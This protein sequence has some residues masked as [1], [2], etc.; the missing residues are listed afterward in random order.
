MITGELKGKVDRIWDH[1]WSNGLS[2]PLAVI[3]QI[4]YLLFMKRL[5]ELEEAEERKANRTG[6]PMARRLFN[7]NQQNLRWS[8]FKDYDSER[9]FETVRDEVF[10]FLRTLNTNKD[11][12]YAKFMKDAVFLIPKPSVLEQ[13][14]T[15][16]SEIPMHDRDTKGDLYEYLLGKLAQAGVNG[17]FRTPRHIIRMM[18]EMVEP[19]PK[20]VIGDPAAGTA[21]FLVVAG[22]YLLEKHPEVMMQ[23]DLRRHFS[24]GMF[25]GGEFD[26]TMM[27]IGA[28]NLMMHGI[29]DPDLVYA[30]SLGEESVHMRNL[31]TLILAN[32][33][34]KGAINEAEIAKDLHATVKTKKTEL[35]FLALF[36]KQLKVGGRCACIVPDGVLFGASKAHRQVR[37]LLIDGNKLEGIVS[38]PSGVFKPYAGVSTA[39][40]I[41]TRTDSGGTDG[42]WFYDM[43]AD[44]FS[45]DDKRNEIKDNDIP[46]V[47]AKWRE[48]DADVESDRT[49]KAFF[50]SVDEIRAQGYDLSINRYKEGVHE[51][52]VHE[53]PKT[54]LDRLIG[55]ECEIM[56]DL[57]ALRG[58]V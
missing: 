20:D 6:Q 3:E 8:R 31:Y 47:L 38:M 37:E 50:V 51:E 56:D 40:L 28:M 34:F 21:G 33:P 41:F 26:P 24:E 7:D 30:D 2:N 55:L 58:M 44:G 57:K 1:F 4:S 53:D 14:V 15:L 46:D 11:S 17:Q 16:L 10:A 23:D 12:V 29:E 13:V 9:M 36:L 45:L 5:D 27:R 42:V 18:V 52:V 25:H 43:Q 49:A 48:R 35:L 19:K 54:I 39:V 32:P 22:E